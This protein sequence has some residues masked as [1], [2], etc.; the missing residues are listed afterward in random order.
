[1]PQGRRRLTIKMPPAVGIVFF[2]S[3]VVAIA[4]LLILSKDPPIPIPVCPPPITAW[5]SI[6]KD[7]K[8]AEGVQNELLPAIQKILKECQ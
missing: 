8:E 4:V 2:S 7:L 1:M 5:K 6:V 3:P